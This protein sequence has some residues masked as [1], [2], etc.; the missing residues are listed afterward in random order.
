MTES[1]PFVSIVMPIRNE[2][3]CILAALESLA[4]QDYPPNQMEIL[5]A[6]GLST[7]GTRTLV[8]DFRTAHPSL[9]IQLMDNPQRI[10]PAGLNLAIR[11]SRGELIMRADGHTIFPENYIRLC[12]MT[13]KS[14]RCENVGGRMLAVG[15]TSFGEAASV[16]ASSPF[17][18]GG[19]LFHYGS[20]AAWADSVYLGC[21]PSEI[22]RSSGLFDEELVRDQDDEFNYRLRS[23]GGR[24]WFNPEI[25]SR[26]IARSTPGSLFRQYFQYGFWKVRVLQKH[27]KQMS[28]RQFVPPLFVLTLLCSVVLALLVPWGW[29]ILA[30]VAGIYLIANLAAAI[31]NGRGHKPEVVLLLPLAY[32][33]IHLS[34]GLGFLVGLFRFARRWKDKVGKVPEWRP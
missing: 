4:A 16:A 1:F 33:I 13:S 18:V 10:V 32:A 9:S 17:G 19:A 15:E 30:G 3:A 22:F 29:Y 24:I 14:M 21:W 12:V 26:Y 20:R 7:D 25:H 5:I 8:S 28:P 23:H 11:A 2:S 31:K 34:Y 27:P 6:D